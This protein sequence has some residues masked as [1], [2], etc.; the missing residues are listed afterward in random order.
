ME[1]AAGAVG[2]H[3]E[4][5]I[6]R[7]RGCHIHRVLQPL[8]GECPPDVE[9]AACR[10][11]DVDT[12]CPVLITRI[13]GGVVGVANLGPSLVEVLCLDHTG[14]SDGRATEGRRRRRRR[15]EPRGVGR[16]RRRGHDRMC[17]SAAVGPRAERQRRSVGKHL[18]CRLDDHAVVD[19]RHKR[20]RRSHLTVVD[21]Q[22][23][24]RR[25]R[26]EIES[27]GARH[28]RP[29]HR[30]GS[31]LG[32]GHAQLDL[33]VRGSAGVDVLGSWRGERHVVSG[34]GWQEGMR[35]GVVM[36]NHTPRQGRIR[37]R[38]VLSIRRRTLQHD[39]VADSEAMVDGWRIDRGLRRRVARIDA[40]GRGGRAPSRIADGQSRG[41]RPGRSVQVA[42]DDARRWRAAIGEVPGVGQRVTIGIAAAAGVEG[43]LKGDGAR[44]GRRGERRDGGRFSSP[45]NA[46][47]RTSPP[48]LN[49]V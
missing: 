49:V 4:L 46:S 18:R 10:R 35:V 11:F 27:H 15:C 45:T 36:P 12:S 28:E 3:A 37:Q 1:G 41:E 14:Q 9:P 22:R 21:G 29:R 17:G 43:D 19:P 2:G 24:S 31:T 7:A 39:R 8:A 13:P 48:L 40:L 6:V 44:V 30:R 20:H 34:R 23:R 47:R 25:I 32:V 5:D 42:N 26:R 33:E 38:A 16:V